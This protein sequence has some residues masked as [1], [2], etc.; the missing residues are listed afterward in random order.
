MRIGKT[1]QL[2]FQ[3]HQLLVDRIKLLNQRFDPRIIDV[4]GFQRFHD[5]R[6]NAVIIF[7]VLRGQAFAFH[8]ATDQLFLQLAELGEAAGHLVELFQDTVAQ[9]GFHAG[10]GHGGAFFLVL[11]LFAG[12]AFFDGFILAGFGFFL[13][14]LLFLRRRVFRAIGGFQIDQ[15]AQ[16]DAL[17]H[18]L[19]APDH[20]RFEGQWRLAQAADH[21]VAAR[22]DPLGNRDLA[23]A[24]QEL[25]RAHFA[26]IHPHR[27]IGPVRAAGIALLGDRAC[28]R[29]R[30]NRGRLGRRLAFLF[31][32][33]H[34][35][36]LLRQHRH[37]VFDA[38]GRQLVFRQNLVQ[39]L[40]RDIALG[41]GVLEEFFDFGVAEVEDRTVFAFFEYFRFG[42]R[43]VL[44]LSAASRIAAYT[45]YPIK[46]GSILICFFRCLIETRCASP[47][48]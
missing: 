27:V 10:H 48:L 11:A 19:V 15:V 6:G 14:E 33:D 47:S 24:G 28:R 4:H 23:F 17:I 20:H 16:Q 31:T 8:P 46:A 22:F 7:L 30:R 18:Q 25:D 43:H 9:F 38:I 2:T 29:R 3:A 42:F 45:F 36:A 39:L 44:L 13:V 26:Q 5:I 40:K 41:F 34:S 1:H 37:R 12:V 35:D 21:R 32:V